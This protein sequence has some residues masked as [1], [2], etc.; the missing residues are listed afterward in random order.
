M[1]NIVTL[2]ADYEK[3][4]LLLQAAA[5]AIPHAFDKCTLNGNPTARGNQKFEINEFNKYNQNF[6]DG[7]RFCR[8]HS[9]YD[10]EK[11]RETMVQC[12]ACEDWF[13]ESCLNLRE[14]IPPREETSAESPA[15]SLPPSDPSEPGEVPKAENSAEDTQGEETTGRY[16][17]YE[18]ED[19]D[20]DP[21]IPKALIP[22]ADYDVFI[23]GECVTAS[24]MLLKW[25]GS[26]GARMVV[27]SSASEDWFVYPRTLETKQEEETSSTL[28][29]K[30]G[31]K[32]TLDQ[33]TGSS[34]GHPHE[35][36][37]KKPRRDSAPCGAPTPDAAIR[38][39]LEC[40]KLK[41]GPYLE[42][43]GLQGAGDI[44]LTAGWRD[45][46]CKCKECSLYLASRPY[47]EEEEE[48]YEPPEDPDAG[49]SLE[50]LGMKALNTLPRDRAI[51]GIRAFQEMS[52]DL[53][54]FL[55]PFAQEGRV[56]TEK[57]VQDFFESR[58]RQQ[59]KP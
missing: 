18:D 33:M 36:P 43:E 20:D 31:E 26:D 17:D 49:L 44:F 12:L 35:P 16:W 46:W 25:A 53:N 54:A 52:A 27:R 58:R 14:R 37:A 38:E 55:A 9:L 22:P 40:I 51:D 47:L 23:C 32:R 45:R 34:E 3:Q 28:D 39:L 13:H 59:Q 50:E 5:E 42:G 15:S 57:D 29:T 2:A 4:N 7:G 24:P 11:E 56:V 21:S 19:D 1:S 10:G 8:C 41:K 6:R 48:T 30:V